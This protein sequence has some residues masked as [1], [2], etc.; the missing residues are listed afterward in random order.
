M[1]PFRYT[2]LMDVSDI[3]DEL[4]EAQ[5]SAVAA[6]QGNQ[7]VLAGAGSGKTRVLVHRIAWLIRAESLSPYSVMAVTFTNKAAREMR[8]RIETM[9]QRPSHGMWIG[10]FHGL[11]HR[12]L[13]TH[14]QEAGL[15]QNFQILD[16]DDQLRLIKRVC[17]ELGLDEAKW[18]P[19]QAQWFINGQKD[20]G[21]RAAHI[22]PPLGDIYTQ[23]LLRVYAAYE[24]ACQR[25]GLVDFAELLLR[26]HELWLKSPETLAHYQAR[27][28]ILLVDEFQDTN[29][30]QYAWLRVLAGDAI[31]IV[32]VGDDDQSIYGWRGAKIENI[33]RFTKDFRDTQVVRLEQNYRSTKTILDAANGVIAHNSGR[34][35]K[36]LWTAGEDGEPI[37]LY[38]GFNEQDEARFIVEQ[39]QGWT[40]D[41]NLRRSSA[42]LYRS[43]AQSRV[44]EEA[45]IRVGMPYRIYGGQRFYE[46]LEIRNALAYLR[47]ITGRGDDPALERVI[48]TPTRG[49]GSKTIDDLRALA[50]ERA[51]SMWQAIELVLAD[52]LLTPRARTSLGGFKALVDEL[53][54]ETLEL[55]L[56][57]C[58]EHVIHRSGLLEFHRAEKGERGQ[59]RVENLEELVSAAKTFRPEDDTQSPLQQFLDSAALDA[60]DS[61][62]DPYEDSV[63]M[64]TLHSA[65]GLEFPMVILAGLEE[66]L[67]PHR[68]SIEEPGRLE[69]E[70][71]L[72]YVGITRAQQKLLITY[73]ESRRLHGNETYNT[74]S[75]FVREIPSEL[76]EEV[77]L[78]GGLTRPLASV[79]SSPL[80]DDNTGLSLGQPVMHPMFGEGVVLNIEGRGANARIEVNF[81]EGSKWLVLQYANLQAL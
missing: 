35:G 72:A 1:S 33:Q 21:L 41:G 17:R 6:A 52:G 68:M 12:L 38:A 24:E 73:A 58:V 47:L 59:A 80:S 55:P 69:E 34:L 65:K 56:E 61:Q 70:R 3:L 50:R 49:I 31:P 10:T 18:P 48:N 60:G 11:A 2:R 30:I 40:D 76:I 81:A 44:I 29:T 54:S 39:I 26:A 32:A 16:S 25:G 20:E 46:R 42:V 78:H 43:N 36:N 77:R 22:E 75:R 4:N 45:L 23:T 64:M 71:R 14:W 53:D 9:L 27:F 79:G 74:P 63:Q 67:F 15:P 5:R 57:E 19:K 13:Q 62:A 37:R 51:V 66:N 8:G 7:L 28:N